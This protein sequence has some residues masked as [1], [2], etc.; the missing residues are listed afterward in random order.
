MLGH[1]GT[2]NAV[3]G[4]ATAMNKFNLHQIYLINLFGEFDD[5]KNNENF[6][7]ID[8]LNLENISYRNFF[9]ICIYFFNFIN[10][11]LIHKI[12]IFKLNIIISNLIGY[13]PCILKLFLKI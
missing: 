6:K 2:I 12:I 1:V 10:T 4:M 3:I 7:V 9:K 11:I 5:F 8:I 13:I